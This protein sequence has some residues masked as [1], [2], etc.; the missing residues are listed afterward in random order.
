MKLYV[1]DF[2]VFKCDWIVV[3]LDFQTHEFTAFHNDTEGVRGFIDD[4]AVYIGFNT[5]HYDQYILKAVCSDCTNDEIK[6]LN[7]YLIGGGQGWQHPLMQTVQFWFNNSDIKDDM[8][9]GLSL[10]AIEGHLGMSIEEST[11]SFDIDHP[12]TETELQEVVKYCKH[13]VEA[14]AELVKL[15]K[16]YLRSKI[17]VAKMAGLT[18]EKALSMTNAK[19]AAAFLQARPPAKPRTDERQYK[20]PDNLKTEYIPQ[21]VFDFFNRMYDPAVSDDEFFKSKLQLAI[22]EGVATLGFGGIHLGLPNLIW[23]EGETQ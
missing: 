7:D 13:D 1:Y 4:S 19:L 5:K 11:V 15:R 12:L 22:G 23:K 8:Q 14:T 21:E 10:K 20:Y 16:Q 17:Q 3:F 9:E 6:D 2:E 18:A